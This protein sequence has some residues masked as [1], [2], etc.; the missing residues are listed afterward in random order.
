[1]Y[2]AMYGASL[3]CTA[4][5]RRLSTLCSVQPTRPISRL[6][7]LTCALTVYPASTHSPSTPPLRTRRRGL[8]P[9]RL[10]HARPAR[11][12]CVSPRVTQTPAQ[13]PASVG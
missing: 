3:H 2:A 9:L 13:T 1:M 6:C 7:A 12:P 10:L 11:A 5:A 8:E 4:P